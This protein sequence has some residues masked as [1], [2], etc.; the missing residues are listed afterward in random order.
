MIK[1]NINYMAS[2]KN[3]KYLS[4]LKKD[5]IRVFRNEDLKKYD[6]VFNKYKEIYSRI[7]FN[8]LRLKG[9]VIRQRLRKKLYKKLLYKKGFFLKIAKRN[10][11]KV[12]KN[13][14]LVMSPEFFYIHKKAKS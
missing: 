12:I 13:E 4:I 2:A 5:R 1:K 3:S 10:L 8:L 6:S 9:F 11:A 7:N 14:L